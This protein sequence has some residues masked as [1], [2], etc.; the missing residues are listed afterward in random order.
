MQSWFFLVVSL[1]FNE[2]FQRVIDLRQLPEKRMACALQIAKQ[3]DYSPKHGLGGPLYAEIEA[4][5]HQVCNA[6]SITY[7]LIKKRPR[8]NPLGWL[9]SPKCPP[10]PQSKMTNGSTAIEGQ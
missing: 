4:F 7:K 8:F 6:T 3:P 2:E 10:G 1:A 5:N 9:N